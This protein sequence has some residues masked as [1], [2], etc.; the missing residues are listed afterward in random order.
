MLLGSDICNGMAKLIFNLEF[1]RNYIESH[2]KDEYL[3]IGE[4]PRQ[5]IY[6]KVYYVC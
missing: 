2:S 1:D 6:S 5:N 3:S 4:Q